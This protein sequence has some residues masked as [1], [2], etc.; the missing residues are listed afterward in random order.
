MKK[1]LAILR[2]KKVSTKEEESAS[3]VEA[4]CPL[5]I[6]EHRTRL[7]LPRGRKSVDERGGG[8]TAIAISEGKRRR[9]HCS[10]NL[11]KSE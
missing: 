11:L 8:S 2:G 7:T 6:V 10:F 4:G 9:G 3:E 5:E 1:G